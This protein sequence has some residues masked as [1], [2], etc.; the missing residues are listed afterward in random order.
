[1]KEEENF[2]RI[3]RYLEEKM[4]ANEREAFE[5]ELQRDPLL[6]EELDMHRDLTVTFQRKDLHDL[7][8]KIKKVII[9]NRPSVLKRIWPYMAVAA[10]IL[11]LVSVVFIINR[12][13]TDVDRLALRYLDLPADFTDDIGFRNLNEPSD[14]TRIE[15]NR[16]SNLFE[17]YRN[18]KYTE[19]LRFLKEIN[20]EASSFFQQRPGYY[21]YYQGITYLQLEKYESAIQSFTEVNTGD[22][23]AAAA[24]YK[25]LSLLKA[26]GNT[27]QTIEAFQN[28]ANDNHPRTEDANTILNIL[29][30]D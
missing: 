5:N 11:L 23:K 18:K 25:A 28:I 17:L 22:Y 4:D 24:W 12:N 3:E 14:A 21:H 7:E 13:T 8:D 29:Q 9:Q 2:A 10:S 16:I 27:S 6:Q 15:E 19:T 30:R 1:M 26:E 20:L